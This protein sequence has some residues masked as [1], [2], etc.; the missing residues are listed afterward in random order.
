MQSIRTAGARN[1]FILIR[2]DNNLSRALCCALAA[3]GAL[4]VID[5]CH[6]VLHMDRI[7]LTLF[8][9]QGTSD[10]ASGA[11]FLDCRSFVV[12]RTLNQM[13][14]LVRNELDQALRAGSY[15]LAAGYA[16]LFVNNSNTVYYVDCVE[17]TCLYTGTVTHTAV[18]TSLLAG[19]RCYGYH[20]TIGNSIVIVLY[21]CLVAGTFTFYESYLLLRAAALN[22]HDRSN[23]VCYRSAA[24][25]TSVNRSGACSDC[26]S[27]TV[28]SRETTTTTVVA[29]KFCTDQN[30]FFVNL[31]FKLLTGNAQEHTD[32]DTDGTDDN[33]R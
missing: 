22:T 27:Q 12:G 3:V 8:G 28:T 2:L 29:R 10:T 1:S 20:G 15:A 18:S 33:C 5:N 7:E 9:A 4:L 13:L 17:L 24:D 32:D 23:L 16:L 26:C 30:F 14:C 31:N 21:V 25:R 6:I 19:T 11:D